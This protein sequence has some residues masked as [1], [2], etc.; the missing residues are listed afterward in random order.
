MAKGIDINIMMLGGRRCGK[1]SVLASIEEQLDSK[2]ESGDLSIQPSGAQTICAL[3]E[4]RQEMTDIYKMGRLN[5]GYTPDDTPTLEIMEYDLTFKLQSKP[6][7]KINMHFYDFPGEWLRKEKFEE[8]YDE[9]A[10]LIKKSSVF[11]VAID[12]PFL[13]ENP[14]GE[15]MNYCNRITDMVKN[16]F[17]ENKKNGMFI[18][19][20]LKC[21]RYIHQNEFGKVIEKVK[22]T[23]KSLLDRIKSEYNHAKFEIVITPIETMGNLEFKRFEKNA[24]SAMTPIYNFV[25]KEGNMPKAPQPQ[26]CELPAILI[27]L[28]LLE[29]AKESKNKGGSIWEKLFRTLFE[30]FFKMP[31]AKDFMMESEKLKAMLAEKKN[32]FEMVKDPLK[33]CKTK[34]GMF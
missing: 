34:V 8:H 14:A 31:S 5:K 11:I 12:T 30:N 20:P 15:D 6:N 23:Y 10:T 33:L 4:K 7:G 18:F 32:S 21:E 22:E 27:L 19:V 26:N 16:E 2:L 1:T 9:M 13:M 24:V 17:D 29:A 28:Y 3:D 25:S